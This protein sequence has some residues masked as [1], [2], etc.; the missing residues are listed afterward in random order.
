VKSKRISRRTVLRGA[1]LGGGVAVALPWLEAM[2]PKKAQAQAGAPK[3]LV[4]WFTANGTRPDI[5]LP[6]PD[7]GD[8]AGHP[9]HDSLAPYAQKLLFLGGVDQKIANE[10]IGDGH[11]TGMA[12]LLTNEAI[13]PGNLF[14]EGNCEPGMEQYVGWGG[15]ISVDQ[16]VANEIAKTVTTKF[17]S[18]ELGNQ[19]KSATVWSRMSYAG[20]DQPVP[21]RE[22]PNQNFNDFFADL[23]TDPFALEVIRRKR[24]SVLD[25]VLA[26][27]H[28]FNP[29]LGKDD[30]VRL[31]QHLESIRSVEMRLDAVGGVGESCEVPTTMLPGSE[32]DQNDMYPVTGRAQMD[33]L[34]MALACDLTRVGSLQWSRSVSNVRFTWIP[35]ILGEG[36]H[37]LSHYDDSDGSSQQDILDI[38]KWYTE[39][40]AYFIGQLASMTEGEG[41]VL[42]NS[43]VVWVNE[44]GK[45]NSHTRNGIPFILAGGAQG[46]YNTGRALDFGGEA[47]GRLLVS[48]CHAM[49]FPVS[50]F[51]VA[52][53]SQGPLP[54]LSF[55]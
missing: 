5:W 11:Q 14:C 37:D 34:A 24:K 6:S 31:D 16:F 19:V 55:G 46:Y 40:F 12:C 27:Y 21:P 18:L 52:E 45:G 13:L 15:G 32:Y 42:D 43:V 48:L 23:G 53:H 47:H 20:P 8:L 10:S 22:D 28:A 41:S 38:N 44:L 35:Q 50:T 9:M 1:V 17:R 25:A 4:V 7:L 49:G 3:R 30:K 33:L 36:H 2:E 51:G 39:Q 29:R 26:D 54:G